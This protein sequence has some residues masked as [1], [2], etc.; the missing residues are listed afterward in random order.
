MTANST[1][2]ITLKMNGKVIYEFEEPGVYTIVFD[3]KK[4]KLREQSMTMLI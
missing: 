4:S 1:D 2:P 3:G